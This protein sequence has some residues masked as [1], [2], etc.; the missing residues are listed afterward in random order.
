MSNIKKYQK[1]KILENYKIKKSRKSKKLNSGKFENREKYKKFCTSHLKR[2]K[3]QIP[4]L[5]YSSFYIWWTDNFRSSMQWSTRGFYRRPGLHNN[6]NNC[7][8]KMYSEEMG[9]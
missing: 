6:Y 3:W 9:K 5:N 4:E 1:I 7:I 8:N 2:Y